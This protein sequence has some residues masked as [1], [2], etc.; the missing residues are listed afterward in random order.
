[1]RGY[2]VALSQLQ[3]GRP[4]EERDNDNDMDRWSSPDG[5]T[6]W[7]RRGFRDGIDGARKDFGNHRRPSVFNREEYRDPRVPPPF[8]RDYKQGFRRG[9]E[10]AASRLW[11]GM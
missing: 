11:E 10:M 8:V 6:E 2:A 7:Q 3:G 5:F 4:W 1:M 9:Y